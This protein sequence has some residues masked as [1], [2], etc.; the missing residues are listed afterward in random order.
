MTKHAAA[1]LSGLAIGLVIAV[2]FV[3]IVGNMA[4][5]R[6]YRKGQIDAQTGV[7]HW[8]QLPDRDGSM[9]WTYVGPTPIYTDQIVM[10]MGGT[11]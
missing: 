11:F 5:G 8:V 4:E 1:F 3:D 6:G 2:I 9:T 10:P 7:L